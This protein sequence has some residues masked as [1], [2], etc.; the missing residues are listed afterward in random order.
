MSTSPVK[1]S[2]QNILA[3]VLA[4]DSSQF[5]SLY[6]TRLD[7]RVK[8][9]SVGLREVCGMGCYSGLTRSSC[10]IDFLYRYRN[11]NNKNVDRYRTFLSKLIQ[12]MIYI[13]SVFTSMLLFLL[14]AERNW[15]HSTCPVNSSC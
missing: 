12:D 2:S 3:Q 11:N 9:T 7:L 4:N 15:Y 5:E 13:C 8:N 10:H 1:N 14:Y 6:C